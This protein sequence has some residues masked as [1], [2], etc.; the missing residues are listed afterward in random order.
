MT[1][2]LSTLTLEMEA[3]HFF[4][5]LF[6]VFLKNHEVKLTLKKG[7][8]IRRHQYHKYCSVTFLSDFSNPGVPDP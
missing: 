5:G 3:Y 7:K 1:E 2:P 6:F 8:V 4:H